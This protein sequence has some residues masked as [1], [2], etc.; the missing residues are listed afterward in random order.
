MAHRDDVTL[1]S[2]GTQ[3]SHGLGILLFFA[4][5]LAL[6]GCSRS[7][8]APQETVNRGQVIDVDTGKPIAGVIVVGR[9]RGSVRGSGA[10]SCNRVESAVSDENGWFELPLDPD[11]GPLTMEGYHRDYR[12]G[13]PVRV[14]VC[15]INRDPDQ[16]QIWQERRDESDVVVSV[17]KEPKIYH[18][19]VE[20]TKESRYWQDVYMKRFAGSREQRIRELWRLPSANSCLAPPRTSQ[21][22]LPFLQAILK[23]QI[24]LG[25]SQ[26]AIRSTNDYIEIVTKVVQ[27]RK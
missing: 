15:G 19:K 13:W 20:A 7:A 14:P 6:S 8:P 18:G 10:S 12:H 1:P 11:A 9:Y 16:C 26:D 17:V 24:D 5:A 27:T 25:D 2:R 21:G 3:P 4:C 23:E 22:L